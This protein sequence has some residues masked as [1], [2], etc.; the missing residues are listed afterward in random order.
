MCQH[1]LRWMAIHPGIVYCHYCSKCIISSSPHGCGRCNYHECD[2][3]YT[4]KLEEQTSAGKVKFGGTNCSV[5]TRNIYSAEPYVVVDGNKFHE[6]CFRTIESKTQPTRAKEQ[7]QCDYTPIQDKTKSIPP[8]LPK[9]IE[10]IKSIDEKFYNATKDGKI[11]S[12]GHYLSEGANKDIIMP[13]GY[14]ALMIASENGH[15]D[16]VRYLLSIGVNIDIKNKEDKCAMLLAKN[17]TVL[18]EFL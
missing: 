8:K 11:Y 14:T 1:E 17:N 6:S 2:T 5:C 12:V 18:L 15:L 3:C 13:N 16:V 10:K 7:K 4:K 9:P